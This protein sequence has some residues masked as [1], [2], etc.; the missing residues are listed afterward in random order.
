MI[1]GTYAVCQRHMKILRSHARG[2]PTKDLPAPARSHQIETGL[3]VHCSPS[4]GGYTQSRTDLEDTVPAA[5]ST[6]R[7]LGIVPAS[8][9]LIR[10][11]LGC[12][13]RS[14]APFFLGQLS[15]R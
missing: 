6:R 9:S 15:I 5:Q 12:R 4:S 11:G 3:P 14:V 2:V 10:Q 7:E 13:I 1:P 8:R